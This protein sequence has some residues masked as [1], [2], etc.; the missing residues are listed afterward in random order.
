MKMKGIA[1]ASNTVLNYIANSCK[2][3][4]SQTVRISKKEML[5]KIDNIF[6]EG[7]SEKYK[8]S[9]KEIFSPWQ[10]GAVIDSIDGKYQLKTFIMGIFSKWLNL[11]KSIIWIYEKETMKCF[12]CRAWSVNK[13]IEYVKSK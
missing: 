10:K 5:E 12:E 6:L 3:E 7:S 2:G 4:V 8:L 13:I 9:V 11:R 1:G